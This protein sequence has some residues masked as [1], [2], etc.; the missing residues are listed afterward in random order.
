MDTTKTPEKTKTATELATIS[1]RTAHGYLSIQPSGAIEFRPEPGA[2][3]TFVVEGARRSEPP[4]PPAPTVV[5][6]ASQPSTASTGQSPTTP[7]SQPSPT[8]TWPPSNGEAAFGNAIDLA[9][10]RIPASDCPDVRDWPVRA[11]LTLVEF[12]AT[13]RFE[14]GDT[15]VDFPGRDALPPAIGSQGPIAYTLWMGCCLNDRG[16]A[17][18]AGTWHIAPIVECIGAYVPT[19]PLLKPGQVGTNL[20]YY[21]D[22]PLRG[23]QPKPGEPVALFCTTGDTRRQN[24]QAL[25]EPWRTNVVLV[26]FAVG[27]YDTRT[28][29]VRP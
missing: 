6:P 17:D 20:L 7:T 1:I 2:W 5:A 28:T 11:P 23:Y 22:P 18:R 15:M 12:A 4:A 29:G 19:G 14:R 26:P 25:A 3:E 8:H 21:P 16:V 27:R 10:A 9:R 13:E 24:A